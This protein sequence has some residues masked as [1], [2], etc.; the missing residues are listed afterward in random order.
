MNNAN[1]QLATLTNA[2]AMRDSGQPHFTFAR[3]LLGLP[4]D[5]EDDGTL[6]R[7]IGALDTVLVQDTNPEFVALIA[8]IRER[9][10]ECTVRWHHLGCTVNVLNPFYTGDKGHGVGLLGPLLGTIDMSAKYG[11]QSFA[12]AKY[13]FHRTPR[14]E[15]GRDRSTRS[16][17]T[18]RAAM[19]RELVMP[20]TERVEAFRAKM[21]EQNAKHARW[22]QDRKVGEILSGKQMR[23]VFDL[24]LNNNIEIPESLK[25]AF[26]KYLELTEG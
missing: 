3:E 7:L 14:T 16:V 12:S 11:E 20:T 23:E 25:P 17:K 5:V 1:E 8:E 4:V 26:A 10:F 18:L 19:R 24:V 22:S 9:G 13:R 15:R 21:D 6:R 2:R